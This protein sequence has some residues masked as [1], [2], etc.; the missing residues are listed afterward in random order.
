MIVID[1]WPGLITNASPYA[2]PSGAAVTQVNVQAIVPGQLNVRPGMVTV[3]WASLAAGTSP[4]RRIFRAPC[5]TSERL[6]YQDAA[7]VVREG[8]GPS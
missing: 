3:S 6:V 7:G 5:G 4:V 2:I 8:T 1:K